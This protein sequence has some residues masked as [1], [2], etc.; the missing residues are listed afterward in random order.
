M[1]EVDALSKFQ[2]PKT[3]GL[4]LSFSDGDEYR[5]RVLTTDPVVS[6]TEYENPKTGE[7][8][9]STKFAFIVY[10]FTAEKAQIL[11][12]GTTIAK[13][14][15]RL[16]QDEEWGANIKKMDIKISAEGEQLSRKYTITPLPNPKTLTNEQINEC[17]EIDLEAKI[18]GGS[19]MS[20]YDPN[21]YEAKAI[22]SDDIGAV[23]EALGNDDEEESE[24]I[25][26]EDIPF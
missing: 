2:F 7:I 6:T 19:R 23:R 25:N 20:L 1:S 16:H 18:E 13:E 17:R 21:K 5:V 9:L 22:Q 3:K 15:Q 12:A 14:I 4:F 26:L 11:N 8:T 10:N 24:P